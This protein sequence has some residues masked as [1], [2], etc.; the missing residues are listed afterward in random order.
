MK[1]DLA[2]NIDV[3]T[4]AIIEFAYKNRF[5]S[6]DLKQCYVDRG[7]FPDQVVTILSKM[8]PDVYN[9]LNADCVK[10]ICNTI[11]SL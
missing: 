5:T 8:I 10:L 6:K 2:Y 11:K 4:T 7:Y 1:S 9:G 3:E